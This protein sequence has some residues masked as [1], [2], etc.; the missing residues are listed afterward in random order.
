MI[1][2]L[3]L[4]VTMVNLQILILK[5]ILLLLDFSLQIIQILYVSS[6]NLHQPKIWIIN[7]YHLLL[8]H[9][10][11]IFLLNKIQIS[12]KH[13]TLKNNNKLCVL[14]NK[15]WRNKNNLNNGLNWEQKSWNRNFSLWIWNNLW[16]KRR[17]AFLKTNLQ[18]KK[19]INQFRRIVK[20]QHKKPI[21]LQ[22]QNKSSKKKLR[23]LPRHL[24]LMTIWHPYHL[25]LQFLSISQWFQK[26][27][28]KSMELNGV[29]LD[30]LL[31]WDWFHIM[32]IIQIQNCWMF[33]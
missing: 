23:S 12:H 13:L 14:S 29:K 32:S 7:Y 18:M 17:S 1:S 19:K 10:I 11:K 24:N 6:N 28:Q 25:M 2:I 4:V 30:H 31:L 22:K 15:L 5:I 16:K 21:S 33:R 27:L 20:L 3:N 8:N 26:M 9:H